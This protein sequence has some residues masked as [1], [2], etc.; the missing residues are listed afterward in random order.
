MS[1]IIALLCSC[2]K[3]GFPIIVFLNI[4]VYPTYN[5]SKCMVLLI[6]NRPYSYAPQTLKKY[7]N[8][9]LLPSNVLIQLE[10]TKMIVLL[11]RKTVLYGDDNIPRI[12]S[13]II[14]YAIIL[15]WK[16]LPFN[17]SRLLLV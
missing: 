5:L 7:N 10:N 8:V 1:H 4:H 13:I 11:S 17:S 15:L 12:T 14:L 3:Y 16:C 6:T 2:E 9:E